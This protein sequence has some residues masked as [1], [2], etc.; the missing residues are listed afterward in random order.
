MPEPRSIFH[1]HQSLSG[2]VLGLASAKDVLRPPSLDLCS[3]RNLRSRTFP[4]AGVFS[5]MSSQHQ[6]L[7]LRDA[8]PTC[9]AEIPPVPS[10]CV[11][12]FRLRH[13]LIPFIVRTILDH[14]SLMCLCPRTSSGRVGTDPLRSLAHLQH[15]GQR[16]AQ[17]G[18][19]SVFVFV[20]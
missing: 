13:C 17:R 8:S 12:L 1:C 19:C 18:I 4:G 14:L 6:R 11:S 20:E 2:S 3:T 16:P 10:S 9:L 7:L 15:R 5:S